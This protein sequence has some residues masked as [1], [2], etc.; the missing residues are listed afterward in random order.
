MVLVYNVC[1]VC[2]KI[3]PG[4]ECSIFYSCIIISKH[5]K[6]SDKKIGNVQLGNCIYNN[7]IISQKKVQMTRQEMSAFLPYM[8][9]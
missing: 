3:K 2:G 6:R 1:G 5:K 9:D 7:N 8:Q 4:C